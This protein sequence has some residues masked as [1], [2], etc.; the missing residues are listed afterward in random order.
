MMHSRAL[1]QH[2]RGSPPASFS[3]ARVCSQF[4][5]NKVHEAF[6]DIEEAHKD[7]WEEQCKEFETPSVCK[8][9]NFAS[10]T[11]D[12]MEIVRKLRTSVSSRSSDD[13][14]T[15]D[16]K[17]D[18][19]RDNKTKVAEAELTNT[20]SG[21]GGVEQWY[22][23]MKDKFKDVKIWFEYVMLKRLYEVLGDS[24][25]CVDG[26]TRKQLRRAGGMPSFHESFLE[27]AN[28]CLRFTAFNVVRALDATILGQCQNGYEQCLEHI[29]LEHIDTK[30]D[31][32]TYRSCFAVLSDSFKPKLKDECRGNAIEE[33][34]RFP[35]I[36][37]EASKAA[38]AN[39]DPDS[40]DR[41]SDV[42]EPKDQRL[43]DKNSRDAS[44]RHRE[45]SD[46]ERD[47]GDSYARSR[48][49]VQFGTEYE[50]ERD[51]D[52]EREERRHRRRYSRNDDD[53]DADSNY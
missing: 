36:V 51:R 52:D 26:A 32:W 47:G 45:Y 37:R 20:S 24:G 8:V 46:D 42:H 33:K 34:K 17:T 22:E 23:D 41:H 50:H 10:A 39:R 16:G 35:D 27:I 12:A 30:A 53:E 38:R 9:S 43:S 21:G 4:I 19:E 6:R 13:A 18:E 15:P 25:I 49:R 29:C 1:L 31:M 28:Q 44:P 7:D 40:R 14:A 48:R 5:F 2:P 11:A 3:F